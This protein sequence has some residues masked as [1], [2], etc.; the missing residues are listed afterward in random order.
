MEWLVRFLVLSHKEFLKSQLG[1]IALAVTLIS[2]LLSALMGEAS[3][4]G[5]Q[6]LLETST[7]FLVDI[8]VIFVAAFSG[9]TTFA[10]D[11]SSRGMAEILVPRGLSRAQLL[12]YRFLGQ[13]VNLLLLTLICHLFRW[14]CLEF[15]APKPVD[16]SVILPM[17]LFTFFKSGLTLALAWGLAVLARPVIA[18][19]G[20]LCFM[21]F[22]SVSANLAALSQIK[23]GGLLPGEELVSE[24]MSWGLKLLRLWNPN[25]LTLSS[26]GAHW[27]TFS[28]MEFLGRL[29]WGVGAISLFICIACALVSRKPIEAFGTN[30]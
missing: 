7:Y 18:L 14:A 22:G 5:E 24:K 1:W 13:W 21:A 29:A 3:L 19:L 6:R 27:E 9:S 25:H 23:P 4:S 10:K 17:I 26:Y 8:G 20:C 12:V 11:F 15:L 16:R 30:S 28:L 2:V